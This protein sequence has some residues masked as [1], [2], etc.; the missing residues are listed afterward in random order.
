MEKSNKELSLEWWSALTYTE[1][2][3]Y[4]G[5]LSRYS[6]MDSPIDPVH[7]ADEDIVQE[8]WERE[9]PILS[10]S[11]DMININFDGIEEEHNLF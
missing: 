5:E 6:S 11:D 1:K 9:N 7:S 10:L 3:K 8:I 4:R 2:N